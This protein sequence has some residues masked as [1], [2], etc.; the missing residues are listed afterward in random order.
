[1]KTRLLKLAPLLIALATIMAYWKLFD[2]TKQFTAYDDNA[3]VTNQRLVKNMSSATVMEIFTPSTSVASNYHPL[4]VLSLAIDYKLWGRN[5]R[6]FG[7]VNLTLHIV[8]SILVLL[9]L[10]RLI[11]GDLLPELGALWFA[12]HPLHVE[13]VAWISGRKDVL[14]GVFFVTSI[15]AY[16]RYLDAPRRSA[17]ALC[18]VAF[19]LSCLSKPTAIVL[20]LVLVMLDLWHGGG[21]TVRRVVEKLPFVVVSIVMG[22]I[23]LRLQTADGAVADLATFSIAE[24]IGIASYGF[25]MYWIKFIWPLSLNAFYPY[26]HV[27]GAFAMPGYY[28]AFAAMPVFV[29]VLVVGR[30]WTSTGETASLVSRLSSLVSR[31]SSLG[32]AWYTITIILVLHIISVGQVIMADR[33]TYIPMVGMLCVALSGVAMLMRKWRSLAWGVITVFTVTQGVLTFRQVGMWH[34]TETLWTSIL[35]RSGNTGSPAEIR[36]KNLSDGYL[37]I[38][39]YRGIHSFESGNAEAAY[40]DLRSLLT[41]PS[42]RTDAYERLGLL[43]GMMGKIDESISAYT[44]AINLGNASADAY[45]NRGISYLRTGRP[46]EAS[47]D[48]ETGLARNPLPET[49]AMLRKGLGRITDY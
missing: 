16:L 6:A 46:A 29:L 21:F 17:L 42:P 48:F 41:Y 30:F 45:L 24:R 2:S 18:F 38:Y 36:R 3:Y 10:R 26:P 47:A 8:T 35:E 44:S 40:E 34:D 13:S 15:I 19:V 12:I 33:Y 37:P 25:A 43:A 22:L 4:T 39:I 5:A 31:L 7:L 49:E 9:L 27:G 23:T 32:L 1:M 14:F 11:G 28:Y 20:P